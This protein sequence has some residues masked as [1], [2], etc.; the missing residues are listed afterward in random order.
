MPVNGKGQFSCLVCGGGPDIHSIR[1]SVI[2]VY[3]VKKGRW[4]IYPQHSF[5]LESD[6]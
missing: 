3:D 4:V 2:R 6:D 5:R 1:T